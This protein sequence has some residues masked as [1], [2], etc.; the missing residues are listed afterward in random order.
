MGEAATMTAATTIGSR[1]AEAIHVGHRESPLT[2][3]LQVVSVGWY[4]NILLAVFV[5]SLPVVE[6]RGYMLLVESR[7]NSVHDRHHGVLLTVTRY[8]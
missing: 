5:V 6:T 3:Q 7:P 2:G 8:W 1:E 4:G